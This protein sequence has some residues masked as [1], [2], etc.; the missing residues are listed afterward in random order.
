MALTVDRCLDIV[1]RHP[2]S[3]TLAHHGARIEIGF[4]DLVIR[5]LFQLLACRDQFLHMST[6]GGNFM[7]QVRHI[8]NMSLAHAGLFLAS[9]MS[10]V[11]T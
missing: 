9:L 5:C 1:P 6:N 8:L 3:S 4:G 10:V 2:R 7:L 11:G